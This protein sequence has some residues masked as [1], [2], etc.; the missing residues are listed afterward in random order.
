MDC[1]YIDTN[2]ESRDSRVKCSGEV[3]SCNR[4]LHKGEQCRGYPTRKSPKKRGRAA[5]ARA[6]GQIIPSD[7]PLTVP[8]DRN[9]DDQVLVP[10][11]DASNTRVGEGLQQ[12]VVTNNI[13]SRSEVGTDSMDAQHN[14][15]RSFFHY[16]DEPQ[17]NEQ[18]ERDEEHH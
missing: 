1:N 12:S 7:A 5:A 15:M 10:Q 17:E 2:A 6:S 14:H 9:T 13:T 16:L 3:P 8:E 11:N 4:C 18:G